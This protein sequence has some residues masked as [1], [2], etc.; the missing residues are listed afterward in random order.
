MKTQNIK[1]MGEEIA[2]QIQSTGCL[3]KITM[4]QDQDGAQT[5]FLL[6]DEVGDLLI[7]QDFGEGPKCVWLD[8]NE[9]EAIKL[10]LK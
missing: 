6:N 1:T 10:I 4:S 7:I 2:F 9:M 3:F 8:E 5:A